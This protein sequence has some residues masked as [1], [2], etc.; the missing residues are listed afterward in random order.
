[1]KLEALS[2]LFEMQ[3]SSFSLDWRSS[4]SL[5]VEDEVEDLFFR[6]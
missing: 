1:M 5:L 3:L 2:V 4:Q 6:S